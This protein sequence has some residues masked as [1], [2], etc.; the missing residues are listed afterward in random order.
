MQAWK[1][2][3]KNKFVNTYTISKNLTERLVMSYGDKGLKV[4]ITR[5]TLVTSLSAAPCPGYIGNS[6]GITGAILGAAYGE[7]FPTLTLLVLHIPVI[8]GRNISSHS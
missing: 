7:A 4:C 8:P 2:I 1:F 5:P 6:S 3:V